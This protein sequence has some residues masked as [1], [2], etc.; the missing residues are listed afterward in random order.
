ME[1]A[2]Q[3]NSK[4]DLR[5]AMIFLQQYGINTNL[6]VKIYNQYGPRV[7][8]VLQE[9]PYQMADDIDGV[10]FK[11][12]DEIA[13]RIGIRTDSDFRIRSGIL[14][15]LQQAAGEGHT[16]LPMEELTQRTALL[17]EIAPEHIEKHYMNLAI[18]RKLIMQQK[19][20]LTAAFSSVFYHM[21][22]NTAAMVK[23][24]DVSY[25]ATDAEIEKKVRKI[26]NKTLWWK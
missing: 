11:T 23:Q 19:G 8:G 5:Q 17:L 3:V 4:K 15:S 7:Y 14:Y 6:A 24:L 26:E 16:Y 10:G 2:D 21:E 9:N 25:E 20:E 12:A 13:S 22:A 18:D 1:I